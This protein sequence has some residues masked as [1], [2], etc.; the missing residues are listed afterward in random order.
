MFIHYVL[1]NIQKTAGYMSD[2]TNIACA[3]GLRK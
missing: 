3:I 2:G 1:I